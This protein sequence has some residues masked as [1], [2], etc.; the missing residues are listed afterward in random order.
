ET[1]RF[2]LLELQ[3]YAAAAR[4]VIDIGAGSGI[5]SIAVALLNSEATIVGLET[6]AVACKN[7]GENFEL[8]GVTQRISLIEGSTEDLISRAEGNFDLVLANLTYEDHLALLPDYLK[9]AARGCHLIF[10]GILKEKADRMAAELA[11][12]G[13][14]VIART[15]GEKW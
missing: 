15:D 7:A 3:K 14:P 1:T 9:L 5:L 8:N 13:L 12:Y 10:A 6:D 4:R 2:C 11:K